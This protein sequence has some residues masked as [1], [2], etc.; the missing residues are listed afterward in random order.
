MENKEDNNI[1]DQILIGNRPIP[2]K[3]AEKVLKSICKIIINK[4]GKR[5]FGTGFFMKI[6]SS[7]NFLLTNFHVINPNIVNKINSIIHIEINNQNYELILKNRFIKYFDKP[8]DV[9][10]IQIK[11]ED[12]FF[13]NIEFLGY[14]SNYKQNGYNIYKDVDVFSIQ[15]PFGEDA[16]IASGKI[17]EIH[18]EQFYHSI[19]TQFGS[20][21]C[22]IILNSN[23]INLIQVIGI[24]KNA[25]NNKKLNGGTFIGVIID[26]LKNI[27][28]YIPN[29]NLIQNNK[30]IIYNN[31]FIDAEIFIK[32]DDINKNIQIINSFE[33]HNNLNIQNSSGE[34]EIN[35][36]ECEIIINDEL[37]FPFSFTHI[38]NKKG[39]YK[40]KY[41]FKRLLSEIKYLFYNCSSLTSIDLSELNTKNVTDMS[42]IFYQCSSLT[43]I[44]FSNFYTK[45]VINMSNMFYGCSSLTNLDLSNFDTKNVTNMNKMFCDCVSLI[46][47]DLSNFHTP[48]VKNI[49]MMFCNCESLISLDLSNFNTKNVLDRINF[50]KIELMEYYFLEASEL[51]TDYSN[52]AEDMFNGCI[53]L[54]KKNVIFNDD[55]IKK[56]MDKNLEKNC[57]IF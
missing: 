14:D 46:S 53:S 33:Q 21:G 11:S 36:R 28:N 6:T 51:N 49:H 55:K 41:K 19:S 47:L 8:I 23:N 45:N 27:P 1:V 29:N 24:H 48:N 35:K 57:H 31:N 56:Q 50:D 5:A 42:Y 13:N 17:E 40:I 15:H 7:L 43:N 12:K 4:E 3:I 38:F 20:S 54:K 52:D 2:M 10:V 32:E 39:K 30:K 18:N 22:P 34:D 25:D 16:A 44:N 37:V 26:E 9:T